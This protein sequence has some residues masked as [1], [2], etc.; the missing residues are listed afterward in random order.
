MASDHLSAETANK[1]G[2][3]SVNQG[4]NVKNDDFNA[5]GE[6]SLGA[7]KAKRVAPPAEP[8]PAILTGGDK[9]GRTWD[10]KITIDNIG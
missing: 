4:D 8:V 1:A 6:A 9:V 2:T 7:K 10:F 5:V 3:S